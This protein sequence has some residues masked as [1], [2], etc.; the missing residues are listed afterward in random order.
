MLLP[1]GKYT[2][3]LQVSNIA[4]DEILKNAIALDFREVA[5][6]EIDDASTGNFATGKAVAGTT[7]VTYSFNGANNPYIEY[8]I[9]RYA[10]TPKVC[11]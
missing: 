3:D 10:D 4:G 8:S 9:L 11:I 1:S 6:F 2:V 7:P 5:P